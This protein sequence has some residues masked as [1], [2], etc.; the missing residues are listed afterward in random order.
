MPSNNFP[1]WLKPKREFKAKKRAEI[2]A[3]L[4]AIDDLRGGCAYMPTVGRFTSP[5]IVEDIAR[6]LK[7]LAEACSEKEWGR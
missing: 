7:E 1:D 6:Q 2:R 4:K 3:A 5:Q